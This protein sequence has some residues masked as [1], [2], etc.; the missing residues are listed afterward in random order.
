MA[1]DEK[2]AGS[3]GTG[4]PDGAFAWRVDKTP[5]S[6]VDTARSRSRTGTASP[7]PTQGRIGAARCTR[8]RWRAD[9]SKSTAYQ[10]RSGQSGYRRPAAAGCRTRPAPESGAVRSRARLRGIAPVVEPSVDRLVLA[11]AIDADQPQARWSWTGVAA[12]AGTTSEKSVSDPPS[13]RYS[14]YCAMPPPIRLFSS[15]RAHA[16]GSQLSAASSFA[17]AGRSA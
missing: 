17:N 4:Y 3:F 5:P 1:L 12:P 6:R 9:G 15:G 13:A 7:R 10:T 11:A 2:S 16:S 8:C 14:A